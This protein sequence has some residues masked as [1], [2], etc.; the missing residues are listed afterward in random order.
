MSNTPTTSNTTKD[1][2]ENGFSEDKDTL[3]QTFADSI[4]MHALLERENVIDMTDDKKIQRAEDAYDQIAEIIDFDQNSGTVS[5]FIKAVNT[6]DAQNA[7]E[8][9]PSHSTASTLNRHIIATLENDQG[10]A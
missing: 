7:L 9:V 3:I 6:D 2:L 8:S 5:D 10:P 1:L 4:S